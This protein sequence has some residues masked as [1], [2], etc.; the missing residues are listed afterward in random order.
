MVIKQIT[1]R[2]SVDAFRIRDANPHTISQVLHRP[3]C[4]QANSDPTR[5]MLLLLYILVRQLI[6]STSHI[7]VHTVVANGGQGAYHYS[8]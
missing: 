1:N 4:S 7:L 5:T 6:P 8:G 3:N 2:V